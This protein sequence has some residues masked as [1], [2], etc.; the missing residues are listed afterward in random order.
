MLDEPESTRTIT[1]SELNVPTFMMNFPSTV[2]NKV[3]NNYWM[4]SKIPYNYPLVFSQWREL[5]NYMTAHGLV[6]LLPSN[7]GSHL[8]DL[9][10]VANIG[11]SIPYMKEATIIIS[12]FWSKVRRGEDILGKRFLTNLGYKVY[13][14]EHFFEGEAELKYI[15]DNKWIGG[16]GIRTDKRVYDWMQSNFDME[17]TTVEMADEKLYHFDC[18]FFPIGKDKALVAT[19]VMSSKDLRAI[20]RVVDIIPIPDEDIYFGWTNCIQLENQIIHSPCSED[21]PLRFCNF[22]EKLGYEPVVINLSEFE[23]SGGDASCLVFQFNYINRIESTKQKQEIY[24]NGA[25]LQGK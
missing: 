12:N 22:I 23:K 20:E 15:R 4:D 17:I 19:S 6:Y 9:C 16:Y 14:P 2:S 11:V 3:P 1:P 25:I 21:N 13:K 7:G 18:S 10:F 8:Q 24:T 5:Y